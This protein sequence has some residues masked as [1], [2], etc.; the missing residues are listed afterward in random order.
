[1]SLPRALAAAISSTLPL[2]NQ[3]ALPYNPSPKSL[4]PQES[5]GRKKLI[6][7]MGN[8]SVA[9]PWNRI[10]NAP[11]NGLDCDLPGVKVR[12]SFM[13]KGHYFI[14]AAICLQDFH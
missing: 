10:L 6:L 11:D 13:H 9:N 12:D 5:Q 1:M 8:K 3:R 7:P 2:S 4:Q 14:R